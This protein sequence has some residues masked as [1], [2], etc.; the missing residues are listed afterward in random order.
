M[1]LDVARHKLPEAVITLVIIALAT[2]V[3]NIAMPSSEAAATTAPLGIAIAEFQ[4]SHNI[5]SALLG[6][7]LIFRLSMMVTRMAVRSH[8]YDVNSFGAMS[9][10]PLAIMALTTPGDALSTIVVAMLAVEAMRRLFY[11]F[12]S[13]Q[14]MNA[15]F[16]A[17]L[18]M[19]AMPLMDSALFVVILALPLIIV[20]LR[21]SLRDLI[22]AVVGMVLPIFIYAYVVWCSGG[23]F[24]DTIAMLYHN[25]L[26]P[27]QLST[28]AYLS[29]PR[30]AALSLL[31]FIGLCSVVLYASKS[32]SLKPATRHIWDFMVST[33]VLL[34]AALMLL[35][36]T[37]ATSI[38]VVAIVVSTMAPMLFLRLGTL[39]AV[40]LY[41]ALA[42][43][44]VVAM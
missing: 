7:V 29:T 2:V 18:A 16:T 32:S 39:T 15:I 17:M 23:A 5:I 41:M 42:T 4:Q 36:S 12:S 13:E 30:I 8:L 27:S 37:T 24:T 6:F 38:V 19:G 3:C 44:S 22:I 31:L 40:L 28:E 10:V 26:E 14:R 1:I 33:V 35:P 20:A 34:G 25:M 21:C 9:I 11:A 43:I